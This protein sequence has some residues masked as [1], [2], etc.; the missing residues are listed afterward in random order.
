MKSRDVIT[1]LEDMAVNPE[2]ALDVDQVH[3]L[4]FATAVI[5][6]LPQNQIDC[7]DVILDLEDASHKQ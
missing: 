1:I 3:A 6:S 5:G 4:Y 7:L 2:H